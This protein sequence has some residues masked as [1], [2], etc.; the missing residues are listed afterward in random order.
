MGVEGD[1]FL[2]KKESFC[3]QCILA[4]PITASLE[5]G[6]QDA[7]VVKSPLPLSYTLYSLT[8]FKRPAGPKT[9]QT[10]RAGSRCE[11]GAKRP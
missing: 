2:R 3:P 9:I 10:D 4:V 1:R 11:D 5:T 8:T 6:E 7:Q